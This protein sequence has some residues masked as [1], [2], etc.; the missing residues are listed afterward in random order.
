MQ[1][2]RRVQPGARAPRP[3]ALDDHG[4]Q[5]FVREVLAQGRQQHLSPIGRHD[6]YEPRALVIGPTR[7]S[8]QRCRAFLRAGGIAAVSATAE[9]RMSAPPGREAIDSRRN[10]IVVVVSISPIHGY[11]RDPTAPTELRQVRWTNVGQLAGISRNGLDALR[12]ALGAASNGAQGISEIMN[13]VIGQAGPAM[14]AKDALG[15]TN[16]T[17]PPEKTP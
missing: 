5:R 16:G 4:D 3:P 12:G 9:R 1:P 13:Q 8:R 7:L 10:G 6:A 14:M 2:S 11:A 15:T 17:T